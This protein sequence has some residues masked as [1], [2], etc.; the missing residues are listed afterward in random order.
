[1]IRQDTIESGSNDCRE[2]RRTL[3]L[4]GSTTDSSRA[5][6]PDWLKDALKVCPEGV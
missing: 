2:E 4:R 1:M 5:A 6:T 3:S